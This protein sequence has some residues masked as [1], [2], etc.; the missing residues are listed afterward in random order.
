MAHVISGDQE[1][2]LSAKQKEM[3]Q[4]SKVPFLINI[5]DARLIP[6]VK[7]TAALADWRPYRGKPTA[8]LAE[9]QAYIKSVSA[10]R[11]IVDS[12]VEDEK[13]EVDVG[14]MTKEELTTFAFNELGLAL[15]PKLDP[16]TMRKMVIAT[17]NAKAEEAATA[18][19]SSDLAD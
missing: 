11:R 14:T 16:K 15:D 17:A 2:V 10:V 6:N 13:P 9:R 7:N 3:K 8:T 18:S 4:D 12:S 5:Y 1:S 19:T